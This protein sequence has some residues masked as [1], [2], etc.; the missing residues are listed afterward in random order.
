M[1]VH[2]V[3]PVAGAFGMDFSTSRIRGG[4]ELGFLA[5]TIEPPSRPNR[6]KH[7]NSRL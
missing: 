1:A 6:G 5:A 3:D 7:T 2:H 4:S